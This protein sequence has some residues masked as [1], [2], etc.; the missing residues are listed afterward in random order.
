M[1]LGNAIAI[2]LSLGVLFALVIA[3]LSIRRR[4]SCPST[5]L[6]GLVQLLAWG[7]SVG[8]WA[9]LLIAAYIAIQR[10]L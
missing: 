2:D 4:K 8:I 1:G 7:H 6:F 10:G 5:I 9:F 3:I